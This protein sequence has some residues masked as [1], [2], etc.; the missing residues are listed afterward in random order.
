MDAAAGALARGPFPYTDG[1]GWLY[2]VVERVAPA[3]GR[4]RGA[5]C[6]YLYP[7]PLE[8][9]QEGRV[10][11]LLGVHLFGSIIP[12]GGIAVRRLTGARMAPYTLTGTSVSAARAFYYRTCVFEMLHMPFF[13]TLLALAALRA[14][15]GRWDLAFEDTVVNLALNLY[16]MMHH[17][18]TRGRIA[19]LLSRRTH[20]RPDPEEAREREPDSSAPA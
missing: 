7:N 10:Y 9:W 18:R 16:P 11:R 1:W 4:L 14:S 2:R 17:R 13:L 8:L 20:G 15:E 3:G 19:R 6:R 12:T 5:L